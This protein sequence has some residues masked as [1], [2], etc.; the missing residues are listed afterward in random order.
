M[1]RRTFLQF[2]ASLFATADAPL[3]AA[4]KVVAD[5]VEQLTPYWQTI[6]IDQLRGAGTTMMDIAAVKALQTDFG[7]ISQL[8]KE[9]WSKALWKASS[10]NEFLKMIGEDEQK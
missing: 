2:V 3:M 4:S 8:Q 9:L 5:P 6:T 7:A 10:G 1:K